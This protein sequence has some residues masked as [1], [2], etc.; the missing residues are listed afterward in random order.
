MQQVA[1]A[2]YICVYTPVA[3]RVLHYLHWPLNS[4]NVQLLIEA[5]GSEAQDKYDRLQTQYAPQCV[6]LCD[7]PSC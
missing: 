5:P 2:M 3:H 7:A 6:H 4:N 1:G